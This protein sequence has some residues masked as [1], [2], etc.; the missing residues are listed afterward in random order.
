MKTA[1]LKGSECSNHFYSAISRLTAS[2]FVKASTG[3]C[4]ANSGCP[5]GFALIWLLGQAAKTPFFHGGNTSSILVG[6]P[7]CEGK[8][9]VMF[10]VDRAEK[11]ENGVLQV[12]KYRTKVWLD[13]V[14]AYLS[15]SSR[16]MAS[17]T[18]FQ[19][20]DVGSE[21]IYS[22]ILV[23]KHPPK[24][25]NRLLGTRNKCWWTHHP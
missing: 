19:A 7:I 24:L 16:T 8:H 18:A 13:D 11:P 6:V 20:V 4:I 22:S 12:V 15:W 21:P 17:I 1:E 23:S 3:K 5:T 10:S 25:L 9:S 2:K 14:S